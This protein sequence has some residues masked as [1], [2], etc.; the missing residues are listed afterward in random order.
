MLRVWS[1]DADGERAPLVFIL[2]WNCLALLTIVLGTAGFAPM[3]LWNGPL[4]P[5][6]YALLAGTAFLTLALFLAIAERRLHR[7]YF[8]IGIGVAALSY[9]VAALILYHRAD[10]RPSGVTGMAAGG[11]GMLLA[12][13]PY[14]ISRYRTLATTLLAAGLAAGLLGAAGRRRPEPPAPVPSSASR[15]LN[16]ELNRLSL[17]T[18]RNLAGPL[19]ARGGAIERY[20]DSLLLINDLGEFYRLT[21]SAG[22]SGLKSTRLGLAVPFDRTRYL[23]DQPVPDRAPKLRVTDMIIGA[24]DGRPT[25]YVAHQYWDSAN[26]CFTVRVSRSPLGDVDGDPARVNGNW[27]TVFASLPCLK[28]SGTYNDDANGGRLAWLGDKLLLTVGDHGFD[29]KLGMPLLSQADDNPYGKVL[30]INPAGG[31]DVFSKGHRN[32]QGLF[33]D[34]KQRIWETEHGPSG[35]DEINLVERGRNYG[36]PLATY[37]TEYGRHIW[38]LSAGAPDHG[39]FA[40]P[41]YAFVPSI[42]IS[43]VIGVSSKSFPEWRDDLLVGSLRTETLFRVRIREGRVVYVEPMSLGS[44]IWDLAEGPDGGL[45]VWTNDATVIELAHVDPKADGDAVYA[46]CEVCHE[47]PPGA[48]PTAPSLHFILRKQIASQEGY[49]YS[50]GLAALDGAWTEER[51]DQFLKNPS[52]YAPG[53]RMDQGRVD[54]PDERRAIIEFL[55]NYR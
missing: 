11:V 41:F 52:G 46:R 48:T 43:Q 33:V 20:G 32:P 5:L 31:Y 23:A 2:A 8:A 51:L 35:G 54:D 1:S 16:T 15:V 13:V 30:L 42:A 55:R 28:P 50:R 6:G 34:G 49:D 18:Y 4:R 3:G 29:G 19:P 7:H 40:E 26:R 22:N 44:R 37:G 38:P 25:V 47:A 12:F 45:Y 17:T 53:S 14:V 39:R 10:L 9:G 21:R 24:F 27:V 36:W